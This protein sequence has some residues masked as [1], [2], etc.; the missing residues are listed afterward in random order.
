MEESSQQGPQEDG[1][2][3]MRTWK[4]IRA[5]RYKSIDGFII[6]QFEGDLY[7]RWGIWRPG[8]C[9]IM[10]EHWLFTFTLREAKAIVEED[11]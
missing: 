3:E 7:P 5:G 9:D 2:V 4:R 1:P 6:Q 8:E 11:N 10:N